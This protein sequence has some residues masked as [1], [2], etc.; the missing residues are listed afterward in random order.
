MEAI[1]WLERM[2]AWFRS[3]GFLSRRS[4]VFLC[5]YTHIHNEV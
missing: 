5:I 4:Q 2:A 3:I 1:A